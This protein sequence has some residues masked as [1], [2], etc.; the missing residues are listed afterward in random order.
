MSTVIAGEVKKRGVSAFA[1]ALEEDDEAVIT[2][3]G[4]SR[5]VVMTMDKY[6][7][8]RELELTQAVREARADYDADRI[9]DE[10]V[11]DHMRRIDNEI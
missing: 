2:V 11:E 5:Y 10:S 1:A 8:L 9:S 4:E 3:R 6:N 7:Q